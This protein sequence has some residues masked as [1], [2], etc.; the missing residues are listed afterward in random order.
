M[1]LVKS[2]YLY[3]RIIPPH[4]NTMNERTLTS[5]DAAFVNRLIESIETAKVAF[6]V[7]KGISCQSADD[8]YLAEVGRMTLELINKMY[9]PL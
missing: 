7:G 8:D 1:E 9:R 5:D 4:Y 2:R 3:V 6:H